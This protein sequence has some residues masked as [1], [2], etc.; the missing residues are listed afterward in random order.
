MRK[1]KM[2]LVLLLVCLLIFPACQ[3]ARRPSETPAEELKEEPTI[4]LYIAETGEK[5]EL[6][7]EE[8]LK[9]VVA[10]EMEPSWPPE[11]LAA[12]AI[13]ARTFTLEKM[14][15]GGVKARG[16]DASTDIEEFQAYDESR[17]NDN[18]VKAV[19]RT[20]GEVVTHRGE[21][22]KAWFFADGGGKTAASAMEGLAYDKEP[23]P[24]IHSVE[25]PGAAVTVPENKSWQASFPLEVV[26]QKVQEATGQDPGVISSVN[27]EEKGPSGR[28]TKVKLGRVTTSGPSLRL[29]LG[30]E[31]MRSTLVTS[32]GVEGNN[33]VIRGKG[34]GH[35]VGMSQWGA[36]ALAEQG[37]KAE[38]IIRYFF[39]DVEIK[40]EWK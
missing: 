32:M 28:V 15:D 39:K 9:G 24:Y 8:Y 36:N 12:Q 27:I 20:R 4:S 31:K 25:D 13:L 35:G 19:E 33:L 22:I 5:K 38:D 37:K 17:I 26:R 1:I 7:M 40:Q 34:F 21:Y 29:A 18:I 23:T 30:S 14:E 2:L 6:K 10:A 11:A 16:T 3:Q